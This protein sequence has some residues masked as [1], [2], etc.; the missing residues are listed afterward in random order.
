LAPPFLEASLG[1]R[2]EQQAHGRPEHGLGAERGQPEPPEQ[3]GREPARD[4]VDA[5][6]GDI[7]EGHQGHEPP[8]RQQGRVPVPIARRGQAPERHRGQGGQHRDGQHQQ[9][10]DGSVADGVRV[11]DRRGVRRVLQER[12]QLHGHEPAEGEQPGRRPGPEAA[13]ATVGDREGD[14]E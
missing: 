6:K 4:L 9:V 11:A 13:D 10:E 7:G 1:Q 2:A 12:H 5:R 14:P 8:D 3:G